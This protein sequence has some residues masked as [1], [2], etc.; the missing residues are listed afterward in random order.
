M[1]AIIFAKELAHYTSSHQAEESLHMATVSTLTSLEDWE[2]QDRINTNRE[3]LCEAPN[4][5]N[6]IAEAWKLYDEFKR[7]YPTTE[8]PCP[9]KPRPQTAPCA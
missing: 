8:T 3:K 6:L 5:E 2:L 4:D 1:Q 9:N 7:R